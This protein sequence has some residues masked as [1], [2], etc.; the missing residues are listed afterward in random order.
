[1]L[2]V[3]SYLLN[4]RKMLGCVEHFHVVK[5]NK[6]RMATVLDGYAIELSV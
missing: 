3:E 4:M 6:E 5:K 2:Y 1:M